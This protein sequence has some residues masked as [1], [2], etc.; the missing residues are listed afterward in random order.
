MNTDWPPGITI[1]YD[2]MAWNF[3]QPGGV[4]IKVGVVGT[5]VMGCDK[6]KRIFFSQL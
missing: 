2:A 4:N 5:P 6:L 3:I 1:L